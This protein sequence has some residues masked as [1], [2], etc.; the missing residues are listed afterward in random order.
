[1]RLKQ[2]HWREN[3]FEMKNN[4]MDQDFDLRNER[5]MSRRHRVLLLMFCTQTL[6]NVSRYHATRLAT[7]ELH[8]DVQTQTRTKL[9]PRV[10]R[11]RWLWC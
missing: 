1:M 6:W 4:A 11:R 5:A 2:K 8:T 10:P 9:E 7:L 3:A